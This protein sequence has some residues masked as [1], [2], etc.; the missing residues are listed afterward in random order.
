MAR[1]D[2]AVLPG[3]PRAWAGLLDESRGTRAGRRARAAHECGSAKRLVD[4]IAHALQAQAKF[5]R[6]ASAL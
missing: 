1:R 6:G 4:A 3:W 5:H 2:R